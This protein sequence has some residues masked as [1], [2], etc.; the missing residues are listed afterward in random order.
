MNAV[1]SSTFV[2]FPNQQTIIAYINSHPLNT[3]VIGVGAPIEVEIVSKV[4][5]N[6]KVLFAEIE[7]EVKEAMTKKEME[8]LS[9]LIPTLEQ[10]ILLSE[11]TDATRGTISEFTASVKKIYSMITTS[12]SYVVNVAVVYAYILQDLCKNVT[13]TKNP[14]D[15]W[16]RNIEDL[17]KKHV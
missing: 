7:K 12:N 13:Y 4:F 5:A 8:I 9:D 6:K 17:T 10:T 14:N 2:T 3:A 11:K 15:K 16:V 1:G